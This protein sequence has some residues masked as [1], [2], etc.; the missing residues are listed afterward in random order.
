MTRV[1]LCRAVG[2]GGSTGGVGMAPPDFGR[3]VNPILT[4]GAQIIP[5]T[6]LLALQ[7]F[8]PS[9]GPAVLRFSSGGCKVTFRLSSFF[10]GTV[11]I[12]GQ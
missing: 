9:N 12:L 8:R 2:A 4:G 7:I 3:S 1:I 10:L 6:L 5:E 11:N